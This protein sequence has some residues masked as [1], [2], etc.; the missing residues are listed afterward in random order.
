MKHTINTQKAES[1]AQQ[2]EFIYS[3][4]PGVDATIKLQAGIIYAL[5][6]IAERLD[7]DDNG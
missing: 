1:I 2:N 5:L 6:A 3:G 4:N 7:G